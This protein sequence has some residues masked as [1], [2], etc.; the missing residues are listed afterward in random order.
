MEDWEHVSEMLPGHS[1]TNCKSQWAKSQKKKTIK[2]VWSE[3]E[4]LVLATITEKLGIKS[5]T[6]I[7]AEFNKSFPDRERTRKQ[8]RD[9]WQNNLNPNISK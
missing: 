2:Y 6:A 4:D 9:R 5:W 8:C 1:K 3:E 7:A